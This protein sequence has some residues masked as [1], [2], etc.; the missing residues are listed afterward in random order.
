MID[1]GYEEVRI[2]LLNVSQVVQVSLNLRSDGI[3]LSP[4]TPIEEGKVIFKSSRSFHVLNQE[5]SYQR[6]G[7]RLQGRLQKLEDLIEN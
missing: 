4:V 7:M 5:I 2:L 3:V 1:V 6:V